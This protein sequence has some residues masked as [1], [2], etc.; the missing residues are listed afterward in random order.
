MSL[1]F[2]MI[3]DFLWIF[4]FWWFLVPSSSLREMKMYYLLLQR[5]PFQTNCKVAFH[6]SDGSACLPAV[7]SSTSSSSNVRRLRDDCPNSIVIKVRCTIFIC[8][9]IV[10]FCLFPRDAT[11]SDILSLAVDGHQDYFL[12]GT[13]WNVSSYLPQLVIA[14]ICHPLL[15]R[16]YFT[17]SRHDLSLTCSCCS[18]RWFSAASKMDLRVFHFLFCDRWL[19]IVIFRADSILSAG[20]K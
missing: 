4:I 14:L 19:P 7:V 20:C 11:I 18:N 13:F 9:V 17:C 16:C 3:L 12:S 2:I 10:W 5:S 15:R 6:R 1:Q 8:F